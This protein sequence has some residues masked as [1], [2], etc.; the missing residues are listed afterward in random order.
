MNT[1]SIFFKMQ[2]AIQEITLERITFNCLIICN[3]F[4]F[5]QSFS[6]C[7]N[8]FALNFSTSPFFI[9]SDKNLRLKKP[10]LNRVV[11]DH[12]IFPSSAN[13]K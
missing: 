2:C 9:P 7:V 6:W 1:T 10:L 5:V 13:D 4:I 11:I 12:I 8:G 3:F